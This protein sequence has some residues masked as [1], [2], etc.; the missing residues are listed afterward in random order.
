MGDFDLEV[1]GE[2]TSRLGPYWQYSNGLNVAELP[3]NNWFLT[4][5]ST[6]SINRV[7]IWKMVSKKASSRCGALFFLFLIEYGRVV[8]MKESRRSFLNAAVLV[9]SGLLFLPKKTLALVP[10]G[11]LK[12]KASGTWTKTISSNLQEVNLA[13]WAAGQGWNGTSEAV[14]TIDSGVYLWS[15]N[16]ATPA[17]T[18]GNFPGGLTI[19]NNGYIMGRGGNGGNAD[20]Y[21]GAAGGHAISLSSN[22]S[23]NNSGCILG[24]GGGGGGAK[25][26]TN[27]FCGGGGG[28]GGGAGGTGNVAGGAG[29]SVGT[30]GAN[31]ASGGD[32]GG[33]GTIYYASGGGG[34]RSSPSSTRSGETAGEYVTKS[35]KGNSG[36]ATGGAVCQLYGVSATSGSG[37]GDGVTGGNASKNGAGMMSTAAGGGGGWGAN[38]GTGASY[39]GDQM[40]AGGAAGKAVALNGFQVTWVANG[41]VY[42]A[43]S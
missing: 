40:G 17:L 33:G 5:T 36:G 34:G 26:G 42:G 12:K 13:S 20:G 22:V 39:Y 15:D 14:I 7:S 19:I 30:S 21:N 10:F 28:A 11:F 29:G 9:V 32:G 18:T 23:I 1:A 31:G 25:A 24:G 16:P 41:V 35:G 3:K 6:R 37:G 8:R 27:N 4:A 2:L 43:V 38:G